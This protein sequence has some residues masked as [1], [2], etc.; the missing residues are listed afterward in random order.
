MIAM[1]GV[2]FRAHSASIVTA[3]LLM[4]I[5]EVGAWLG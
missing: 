4:T 1:L 3:S 2:V 5:V